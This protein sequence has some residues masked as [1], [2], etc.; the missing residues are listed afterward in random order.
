MRG[1]PA[2]DN[3]RFDFHLGPDFAPRTVCASRGTVKMSR[4]SREPHIGHRSRVSRRESG[5][6]LPRVHTSVSMSS[7]AR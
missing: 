7:S 2:H 3:S 4:T 5:K 6:L 1:E